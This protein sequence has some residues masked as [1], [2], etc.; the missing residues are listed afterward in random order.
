MRE[1]LIQQGA[2]ISKLEAHLA[3]IESKKEPIRAQEIIEEV[4]F[5]VEEKIE[6]AKVEF[7]SAKQGLRKEVMKLIPS[8]TPTTMSL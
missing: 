6:A 7:I 5:K 4:K 2:E 3:S 1:M 8:S